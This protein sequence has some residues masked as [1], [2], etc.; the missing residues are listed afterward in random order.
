MNKKSL[1]AVPMLALLLG[2]CVGQHHYDAKDYFVN[3]IKWERESYRVL[4]LSDIH[5]AQNDFFDTHFEVMQKTID[6][7]NP[8]MIIVNGDAFTFATKQTVRTLFNWLDNRT[9]KS[10]KAIRWSYVFGNHDDQGQYSDDW[11]PRLLAGQVKGTKYNN[12]AFVNLPDDDVTGRTNV[13][14]NIEKDNKVVYQIY[15]FDSHSYNFTK[16]EGQYKKLGEDYYYD[17][18]KEDQ[19][20]WYKRVAEYSKE[21][22][23]GVKS[24]AYFHIPVPEFQFAL[25]KFFDEDGNAKPEYDKKEVL[26]GDGAEKLVSGPQINTG[27]FAAMDELGITQSISCAHDHINNFAVKYKAE[28]GKNEIYLTYGTHAT[29]RIYFAK[30]KIGGQVMEISDGGSIKFENIVVEHNYE[31]GR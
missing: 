11:I 9:N 26:D 14:L 13:V 28:G 31:G 21:Q 8:D 7:A 12:V 15:L 6:K 27:L 10:G 30:N 2:G 25:D 19:V 29:D 20:E 18:I 23:P 1:Y 4:Q 16:Y 22:F 24:S 5:F 3:G 17:Y